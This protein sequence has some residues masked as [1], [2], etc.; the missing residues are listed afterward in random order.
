MSE[1][2]YKLL[3]ALGCTQ[4]SEKEDTHGPKIL[5]TCPMHEDSNPS[6]MIRPEAPNPFNCFSCE[7]GAGLVTLVM[8]SKSLK[9]KA[10]KR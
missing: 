2:I 7:G 3:E 8:R 1:G 9:Y 6:F 10:A 5:C 4:F